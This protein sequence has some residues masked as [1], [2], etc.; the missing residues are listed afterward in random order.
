MVA[1]GLSA[2]GHQGVGRG[3]AAAGR[4]LARAIGARRCSSSA[5]RSHPR[6][7]GSAAIA[8]NPGESAARFCRLLNNHRR[9][10]AKPMMRN[11]STPAKRP[12][13][14][15]VKWALQHAPSDARSAGVSAHSHVRVTCARG[16]GQSSRPA[17]RA[18]ALHSTVL[19]SFS[20]SRGV[21]TRYPQVDTRG[22]SK[23]VP[24]KFFHSFS[25]ASIRVQRL[26]R[27]DDTR[28][29]AHVGGCSRLSCCYQSGGVLRI[30]GEGRCRDGGV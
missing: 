5:T 24:S 20:G 22:G 13:V 30:R 2:E 8:E 28:A 26:H 14:H 19:P 23:A 29:L 11:A 17:P 10:A 4:G 16:Y 18:G 15:S 6:N 25:T 27:S 21:W 3:R 1:R 7:D 12:Y 9:I